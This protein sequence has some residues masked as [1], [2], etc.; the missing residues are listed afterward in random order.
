MIIELNQSFVFHNIF[1]SQWKTMPYETP[2]IHFWINITY[3]PLEGASVVYWIYH[4]S[5]QNLIFQ[6]RSSKSA[7]FYVSLVDIFI[8]LNYIALNSR[9]YFLTHILLIAPDTLCLAQ[10]LKHN[11]QGN[12]GQTNKNKS[13]NLSHPFFLSPYFKSI[14]LHIRKLRLWES[15]LIV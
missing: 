9:D 7:I 15:N 2:E 8:L 10:W 12:V 6:V 14:I 11:R 3:L 1:C 5:Q 13:N 4:L